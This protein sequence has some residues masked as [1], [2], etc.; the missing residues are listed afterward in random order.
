MGTVDF[1]ASSRRRAAVSA[2]SSL[3][4]LPSSMIIPMPPPRSVL[5]SSNCEHDLRRVCRIARETYFHQSV[6]ITPPSPPP[7]DMDSSPC[8]VNA[9]LATANPLTIPFLIKHSINALPII[10][11]HL[12]TI[13]PTSCRID[14]SPASS[15]ASSSTFPEAMLSYASASRANA[16]RSTGLKREMASSTSASRSSVSSSSLLSSSM[17]SL[18]ALSSSP[19]PSSA[20]ADLDCNF[21]AFSVTRAVLN[22]SRR[23]G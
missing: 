17:P 1:N 4:V 8:S 18:L 21:H 16:A 3:S 19:P 22:F 2:G 11:S 6:C 15:N 7:S 14:S 23:M 12:G 20:A 9:H 5:D 13:F 10:K